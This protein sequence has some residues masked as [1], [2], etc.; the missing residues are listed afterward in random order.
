VKADST[1]IDDELLVARRLDATERL[2]ANAW[3][4]EPRFSGR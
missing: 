4:R 2:A 3:R 1:S